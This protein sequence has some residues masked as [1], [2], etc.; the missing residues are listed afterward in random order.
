MSVG[1][2]AH[3]HDDAVDLELDHAGIADRLSACAVVSGASALAPVS[4]W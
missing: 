4:A 3:A 1:T 2:T